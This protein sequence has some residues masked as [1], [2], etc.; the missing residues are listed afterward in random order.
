MHV[1]AHA[2]HRRSASACRRGKSIT[3]HISAIYAHLFVTPVHPLEPQA[4]QEWLLRT[5][6]RQPSLSACH[7][8]LGVRRQA[9]AFGTCRWASS[10]RAWLRGRMLKAGS[11]AIPACRQLCYDH[12]LNPVHRIVRIAYS[13][14]HTYTKLHLR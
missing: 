1:A 11:E 14:E 10:A 6:R 4:G 7:T 3:R 12:G 2:F 13:I 9:S 5:A 8:S